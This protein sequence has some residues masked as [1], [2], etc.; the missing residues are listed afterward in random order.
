MIDDSHL[1]AQPSSEKELFVAFTL[2]ALQG[3]QAAQQLVLAGRQPLGEDVVLLAL[4][5][6]GIILWVYAPAD[7]AAKRPHE[8]KTDIRPDFS[9]LR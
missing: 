9:Q 4:G 1:H 7:R 6:V 5:V 8:E 2:L 3:L